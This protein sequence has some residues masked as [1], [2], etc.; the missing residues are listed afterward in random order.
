MGQE[1]PNKFKNI[2]FLMVD[3]MRADCLGC[4]GHPVVKTPNLDGLAAKGVRFSRAYAQH[5]QCAPSRASLFTGRYPHANGSISNHTPMGDTET[6]LG[7]LFLRAG[8]RSIAI[9]KTH[10]F[11]KKIAS[12][13]SETLLTEGQQSDAADPE[14]LHPDYK[15]WIRE[16]GYWETLK[17]VYAGHS[18]EA[19]RSS[20]QAVPNPLPVEAYMDGWVG[21]RAVEMIDTLVPEEPF[22]LF[23]SFPGPHNPFDVPEPYASLYDPGNIPLPESFGEDLSV[24]PPQ[25]QEYKVRG[26]RNIGANYEKLDEESLQRVMAQ[27]YGNISLIDDQ[28]GKIIDALTRRGLDEN[29]LILFT[30]DHGE[31][32]GDH[33]LLLKSTDAYPMLYDVSL[34]VP[35]VIKIPELPSPDRGM[36]SMVELIDIAP[37]LLDWAGVQ[38]TSWMQG[39]SLAP[40]LWRKDAIIE[41]NT[42][43]AESGSVKMIRNSR[44]KL[45]YYPGQDYGELY[46][47]EADQNEIKNLYS[48]NKYKE[49]RNSMIRIL[50]DRLIYSEGPLHGE[51]AKG[52][53]YWKASYPSPFK[54]SP[55]KDKRKLPDRQS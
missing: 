17:A 2:L 15:K 40:Y 53:A 48:D 3:Q 27:Y 5:P 22:F 7:E 28:I 30:S 25:H 39:M 6:T 46:D 14:V 34:R 9:G 31:L 33:G 8:Y 41:R 13:F 47:L 45:V 49:L 23:V 36:N 16:N 12:S 24:K 29:T 11:P 10:L 55:R 32:L 4:A 50:L 26:R 44:Y 42:V 19:Y 35:L 18:S 38:N 52:V 20:F 37:T 21:D 43:F 51:S 1:N 54:D